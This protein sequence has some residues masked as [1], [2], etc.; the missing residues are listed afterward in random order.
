MLIAVERPDAAA[1]RRSST[2]PRTTAGAARSW[3][4]TAGVAAQLRGRPRDRG[5]R[6]HLRPR[7]PHRRSTAPRLQI[8]TGATAVPSPTATSSADP[9]DPRRARRAR[10]CGS[11]SPA[12]D[13]DRQR[14]RLQRQLRRRAQ[15]PHRLPAV[16]T[17]DV[18]ADETAL[19]VGDLDKDGDTDLLVGA[20][21]PATYAVRAGQRHART[22]RSTRHGRYARTRSAVTL[23]GL[24]GGAVAVALADLNN[25]GW[26]ERGRL[27][28]HRQRFDWHGS[29]YVLRNLGR[30]AHRRLARLRHHAER[31]RTATVTLSTPGRDLASPSATSTAT[32]SPT[33]SSAPTPPARRF[34]GTWAWRPRAWERLRRDAGHAERHHDRHRSGAARRPR[35]RRPA[36]PG[37]RRCRRQSHY[38]LNAT[39]GLDGRAPPS[40]ATTAVTAERRHRASPRATSTATASSTWSSPPP[41]ARPPSYYSR[42]RHRRHDASWQGLDR[43]GARLPSAAPRRHR[44]RPRRRRRRRPT[45]TCRGHRREQPGALPQ[46]RLRRRAPGLLRGA[47]S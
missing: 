26:L 6:Q 44:G 36:R 30:R 12:A 37:R 19:A 46:Q 5:R 18:I 42:G 39:A 16:T 9:H 11:R 24:T 17:V 32:A 2:S 38:L 40:V 21:R 34:P 33:S 45:S 35:Q 25:D 4:A 13:A 27:D 47:A 10:S 28:N 31:R 23:P 43:P 20:E 29:T 7:R 3:S 15:R 1:R 14:R 22:A 8:N 41:A